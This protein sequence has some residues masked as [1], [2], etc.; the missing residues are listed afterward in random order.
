ML[1][2]LFPL[3]F[4]IFFILIYLFEPRTTLTGIIFVLFLGLSFL[5]IGKFSS[6]HL[7]YTLSNILF[8]ILL[9]IL[10]PL[11]LYYT[12]FCFIVLKSNYTLIRREGFHQKNILS[13]LFI[14]LTIISIVLLPFIRLNQYHPIVIIILEIIMIGS[15]YFIALFAMYYLTY[16]INQFT[17]IGKIDY[18]IVLGS[19]LI[20]NQVPPLLASRINKGIHYYKKTKTKPTI[21]FSGGQGNDESMSEAQAMANYALQKGVNLDHIIIEDQSFS[22]YQNL[23]NSKR[24]IPKNAHVLITTSNFHI[25]RA[26]IISRRL[27]MRAKGRGAHTKFYFWMNAFIREFIAYL[28]D[29][30][31][32]QAMITFLIIMLVIAYNL[33]LLI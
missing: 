18:I 33:I 29:S 32:A 5:G 20:N 17:V 28:R 23:R 30:L 24:L 4:F 14:L 25:L 7:F 6:D 10:A 2:Y 26:L 12:V 16:L 15:Y 27:K 1:F 31:V 8:L 13:I 11:P 21:I 19:G 9:L 22:T 3:I